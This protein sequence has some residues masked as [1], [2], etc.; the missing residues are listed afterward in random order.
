MAKSILVI[1]DEADIRGNL[2]EMLVAESYEVEEAVDGDD[3]VRKALQHP[4]D[5]VVCDVMMPG[6]DGWSV[7]AELRSR[8]ETLEIPFLF[9]TARADRASQRR[10]MEMGAEDYLTKPFTRTE[11]L[12]AVEARLRRAESVAHR[13]REQLARTRQLLS[14]SLPHEILTPLNGILGLST[15]LVEEYESMRRGEVLELAQGIT[16]SGEMLHRLVQ[17]FLRYSEMQIALT[18]VHQVSLMRS[19]SV[20]DPGGVVEGAARCVVAGT[21]RERDLQCMTAGGAPAMLPAH[22]ELVAQ[23]MMLEGL[24]RSKEGAPLRMVGGPC[25]QGWRLGLHVEGANVDPVELK[26]LRDGEASSDGMGLGL[27]VLRTAA[28]LY[29]G[30]LTIDCSPTIGLSLEFVVPSSAG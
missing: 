12:A 27:A 8:E 26:R 11:I 15:M 18:D 1:E 13:L 19:K 6:R 16:T 17:R 20:A 3:G 28:E 7:L 5:L 9:L 14:R 29:K 10:G 23:E 4:P 2:R 21:S 22:L 30:A 25:R 24:R